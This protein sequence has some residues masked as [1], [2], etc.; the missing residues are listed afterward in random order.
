[1]GFNIDELKKAS[2]EASIA[3]SIK[4]AADK[5]ESAWRISF[6]RGYKKRIKS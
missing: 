5:K 3:A 6:Y 1:M 4:T 2:N